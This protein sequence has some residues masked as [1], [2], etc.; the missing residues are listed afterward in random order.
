MSPA[1]IHNKT[2]EQDSRVKKIDVKSE[3]T[4]GR[5]LGKGAFA[6]VHIG[7]LIK[8]SKVERA[9]KVVDL[10]A[11]NTS[12][13]EALDCEIK[14]M[15]RVQHHNI[16][17]LYDC[18]LYH[19]KFIMVLELCKG[20]E[21]FD[22][23][24]SKEHYSEKEARSCF[25]Q[26]VEAIGHCHLHEVVHRDL[27]PENLL[28]QDRVGTPNA[29]V[30]KLADFGL[31]SLLSPD[32]HLSTA[33]GTPGYVSP[34]ILTASKG[35]GYGKEC[36]LWSLGVILY[37]LLCG[38]PPFYDEN[39][40]NAVIF[41]Q[42][43]AGAF[44]F[45]DP[46]W[47]NISQEAKDLVTACLTVDPEK[48]VTC[49]GVF[50]SAWMANDAT[51]SAL[52]IGHFSDNMKKYNLRRKFKGAVLGI[53]AG[54]RVSAMFRRRRTSRPGRR[55]AR[56]DVAAPGRR[57]PAPCRTASPPPR[58]AR[59]AP[60]PALRARERPGT[61]GR[62]RR[63][64]L[65]RRPPPAAAPAPATASPRPTAA[66][67]PTMALELKPRENMALTLAD[68]F[69]N[70]L[71][72]LEDDGPGA[73]APAEG[74]AADD[75]EAD[76][77]DL[78]DMGDD[79]SD[80]GGEENLD[81]VLAGL[82]APAGGGTFAAR[83]AEPGSIG[84]GDD[85]AEYVLIVESN[86]IL[87]KIDAEVHQLHRY[88][89]DVYAKKFPELDTLVPSKMEYMRVVDRM[90]NEMDM[91]AVDL[92]DVLPPTVVMVVSVTGSTT[93]GQPLGAGELDECV[94]G[95][96]E[97]FRLER[98]KGTILSYLESR[99]SVLAPNLTR[100]VGSSLAAMLE[101][102]HL[103]G[104]G[105]TA[106]LPHTGVLYFSDLVQ[107]AP[108][109]LRRKA[110]KIVAAKSAAP[111][112]NAKEK[113]RSTELRTQM[114]K[115]A[116]AHNL[117]AEYGDDSMGLDF[118]M[119]GREGGK[120]RSST[121]KEKQ[122]KVSAKRRKMIQMSSGAT[123]GLSSSLVFTPVQGIELAN[124]EADGARVAAANAGSPVPGFQSALPQS[125][126]GLFG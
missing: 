99:M 52:H 77:D 106:G 101:K 87:I 114:N 26:M 78:D 81:A 104:F 98:D 120:M 42:I 117:G 96:A 82:A 41:K 28:Y 124:P 103:A 97:C 39:N 35:K 48:R 3:Y 109:A 115:R 9:V 107:A 100:L 90:R 93:S 111:P 47:T 46:Y 37:I 88:V 63:R 121:K 84:V 14:T 125:K 92:S 7:R 57:R 66:R 44:A 31:A 1:E 69:L 116:F 83:E 27:K 13:V 68:S 105:M 76:L 17:S 29:D 24:V 6:K 91:T 67:T 62:G 59:A 22:R 36:D 122:V 32:H 10:K 118:G 58:T 5:V 73:P 112:R 71:D 15:R 60:I 34:E 86:E 70:D 61:R 64:G 8:N 4:L 21:L 113:T 30:L 79:E 16:V 23:I 108:P 74:G 20:G 55:A 43:K 33:C 65:R 18:Y 119:V 54:R 53:M 102:R 40:N 11:L 85:D 45:A 75:L 72:E 2:L 56:D 126:P 80:D 19:D 123:N 89:N 51:A 50:K 95:C 110:L 25:A 38:Y 49:E 94:A 12:D